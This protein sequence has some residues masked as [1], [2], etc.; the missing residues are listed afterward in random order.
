MMNLQKFL[1]A[2]FLTAPA[3]ADNQ[4]IPYDGPWEV[5]TSAL[6]YDFCEVGVNGLCMDKP[7]ERDAID[8][9]QRKLGRDIKGCEDACKAT[10]GT[11]SMSETGAACRFVMDHEP[12]RRHYI[13]NA[14]KKVTCNQIPVSQPQFILK[15]KYKGDQDANFLI[16]DQRRVATNLTVRGG[17]LVF[18][19]RL[20]SISDTRFEADGTVEVKAFNHTCQM[21]V[22]GSFEFYAND[23]VLSVDLKYA[24]KISVIFGNCRFSGEEIHQAEFKRITRN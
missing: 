15:G 13:C 10:K 5:N 21:P 12:R 14:T 2:F 19:A 23:E 9:A 7:R 24:T 11:V 4:C 18:P 16:S 17:R 1:L 8:E 22:H 6:G 20:R 3:F